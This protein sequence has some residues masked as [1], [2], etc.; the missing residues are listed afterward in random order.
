MCFC[1][2]DTF[3]FF[4]LDIFEYIVVI[5]KHVKVNRHLFPRLGWFSNEGFM[6]CH[7]VKCSVRTSASVCSNDRT[8]WALFQATIIH[9]ILIIFLSADTSQGSLLGGPGNLEICLILSNTGVVWFS[10]QVMLAELVLQLCQDLVSNTGWLQ[11]GGLS[12]RNW[13]DQFSV[14]WCESLSLG[15]RNQIYL[16]LI[17]LVTATKLAKIIPLN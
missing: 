15:Y 3:S 14:R 1:L 2:Y 16:F 13:L 7:M 8:A 9:T 17:A 5:Q 4:P 6:M 12:S 10:V 11:L